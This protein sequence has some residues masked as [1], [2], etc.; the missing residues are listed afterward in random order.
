M[1]HKEKRLFA[2][3]YIEMVFVPVFSLTV[4]SMWKLK[5]KILSA[6]AKMRKYT[7]ITLL[8]KKQAEYLYQ[9]KKIPVKIP[10]DII[11]NIIHLKV[12]KPV[13]IICQVCSSTDSLNEILL[14]EKGKMVSRFGFLIT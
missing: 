3:K 1:L 11:Q 12:I 10:V 14:T 4:K 7:K 5:L 2:Q 8:I 13:E 9:N 6:F